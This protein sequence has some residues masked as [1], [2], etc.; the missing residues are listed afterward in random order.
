MIGENGLYDDHRTDYEK[1]DTNKNRIKYWDIAKGFTIIIV[2]MGH[3][4]NIDPFIR[5]IIYS[6]HMPFF[7]IANAYFIKN[8]NIIDNL[9]KSAR[10]LLIPYAV[11]CV[12]SAILSAF[13]KESVSPVKVFFTQIAEMFLGFSKTNNIFVV[14][15]GVWLV[16]FVV[17]LFASRMIYIFLM[18]FLQNKSLLLQF[19]VMILLADFGWLIGEYY[20][21]LPWSFDIA[22]VSLTL[23]W[24]GDNLHKSNVFNTHKLILLITSMLIWV[25]GLL[26]NLNLEMAVRRYPSL[27]P[28]LI[29]AAA[30]SIVVIYIS[31]AI[32]AKFLILSKFL[33]WCGQNS[34]IILAVHNFEMRFFNS[35]TY[36]FSN[37]LPI[38]ILKAVLIIIIS[39]II[40]Q[41]IGFIKKARKFV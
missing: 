32:E 8:Y 24:L 40:V 30:G 9:K 18:H 7:F 16:W 31:K 22:L 29:T 39:W 36:I 41:I 14:F 13:L 20:A 25:I 35:Y 4:K 11:V 37:W 21:F 12:I 28:S 1:S 10:S 15:N 17:C 3:I 6:Y 19:T 38:F 33:S 26:L 34:M 23:M 5:N 27:F 2:I